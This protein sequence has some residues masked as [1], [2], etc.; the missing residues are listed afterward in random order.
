MSSD[1]LAPAD[2]LDL[3]MLPSWLK[4]SDRCQL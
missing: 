2:L 4:E 1:P 3:K